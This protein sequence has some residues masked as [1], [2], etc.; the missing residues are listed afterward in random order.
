[1]LNQYADLSM[2]TDFELMVLE[3]VID[4]GAERFGLSRRECL[5]VPFELIERYWEEK[6]R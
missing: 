4:F 1:M 2:F 6:L 3:E 5:D